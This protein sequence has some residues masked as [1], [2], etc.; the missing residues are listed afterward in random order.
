M[1][2]IKLMRSTHAAQFKILLILPSV[3]G[4]LSLVGLANITTFGSSFQSLEQEEALKNG[5]I[6]NNLAIQG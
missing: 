1:V 6:E 4:F 3:F 2:S 5:K